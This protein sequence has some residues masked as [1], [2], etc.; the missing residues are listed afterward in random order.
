MVFIC[1][2]TCVSDKYLI[3]PSSSVSSISSES[4]SPLPRRVEA[5]LAEAHL[6]YDP[7]YSPESAH[8]SDSPLAEV[9]NHG[10]PEL[11]ELTPE[12]PHADAESEMDMIIDALACFSGSECADEDEA[13]S[14][15]SRKCPQRRHLKQY[16]VAEKCRA[17]GAFSGGR[18]LE[19]GAAQ[20][21]GRGHVGGGKARRVE[22]G[23]A[24]E[25]DED[26]VPLPDGVLAIA[27]FGRRQIRPFAEA[28]NY[29]PTAHRNRRH[30][31]HRAR[32]TRSARA[33]VPVTLLSMGAR[34]LILLFESLG[35]L[36]PRPC[37]TK[38]YR[39]PG[40][41]DMRIK[42]R[43]ELFDGPGGFQIPHLVEHGYWRCPARCSWSPAVFTGS[44]L[45]VPGYSLNQNA[46]ILYRWCK[47]Q[48]PSCDEVA[49]DALVDTGQL[50]RHLASIRDLV[51]EVQREDNLDTRFVFDFIR[52]YFAMAVALCC[53]GDHGAMCRHGVFM[54]DILASQFY[55]RLHP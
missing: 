16:K 15:P 9:L 49:E 45:L 27:D 42:S 35:F 39:V 40:D 1:F 44:E 54:C 55:S 48:Q 51:C 19:K 30:R 22:V 32:E 33:L 12:L 13:E 7:L 14:Q 20:S 25:P 50:E 10:D 24:A 11:G 43:T 41:H 36:P 46:M 31:K 47:M 38:C 3:F 23:D 28:A 34:C 53:P 8:D 29:G 5:A 18:P 21:A 37:C 52:F 6:P 26:P 17:R 4:E 2:L